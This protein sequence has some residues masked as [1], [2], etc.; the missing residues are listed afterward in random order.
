MHAAECAGHHLFNLP[1]H[2]TDSS[3]LLCAAVVVFSPEYV[4]KEW[5]MREL[6][7]FLQRK[8]RDPCSIVII[9]VFYELTV[10]QCHNLEQ[11]YD[12]EPWP[13][14]PRIPKVEDKAVLKGWAAGVKKLLEAT[15]IKIE[16]V[17]FAWNEFFGLHTFIVVWV[18]FSMPDQGW[19]PPAI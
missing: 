17:S 11:L 8:A 14:S 12:S 2:Q 10:E 19:V 7:I 18:P 5:T 16:E 1:Q 15:G 6:A 13:T 9:P 4:R 3:H